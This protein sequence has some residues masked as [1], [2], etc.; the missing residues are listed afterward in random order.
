MPVLSFGATAT[1][2]SLRYTGGIAAIRIT[3]AIGPGVGSAR[4]SIPR[5]LRVDAKP[6]DDVTIALTGESRE[7]VTA[8]TGSVSAVHRALDQTV[9]LCGDACAALAAI[10]TGSTFE[11]QDARAIANAL[12]REAGVGTGTVDLD[13]D[14]ACY[15]ADQGRTALEHLTVLAGWSG[16]FVTAAADGTVVVRKFPSPPADTALRYGREIAELGLTAN[17]SAAEVIWTGNGPAGNGSDPRAQLQSTGTL[18]DGAAGPAARTIRVAAP[19]LRTPSVT[20]SANQAYASHNGA[21]RLTAKCW[22]VPGLRAGTAVEIADAPT[23]ESTGPWLVTRVVHTVGPGPAG[24]TTFDAVSMATAGGGG[25]L[26][27]VAGAVGSL[28]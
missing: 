24:R 19:A 12:A 9:V 18:P 22:L 15:V 23:P 14:L 25:L 7:E 17:A 1:I 6:G 21:A 13:L 11:Q 10:R 28:L 20:A 3:L 27:L 8:F 16:A 2:G 5:D 26:D 4:I